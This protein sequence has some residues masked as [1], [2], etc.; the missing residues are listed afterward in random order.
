LLEAR[1][2]RQAFRRLKEVL[3]GRQLQA[4]HQITLLLEGV[5]QMQSVA[6]VTGPALLVMAVLVLHQVFL[7]AA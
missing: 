4:A 1:G 7:V 6:L 3:A 2:T 5:A